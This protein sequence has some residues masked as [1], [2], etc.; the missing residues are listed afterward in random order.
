MKTALDKRFL[1][2][3]KRGYISRY[4]FPISTTLAEQR[5]GHASIDITFMPADEL[6]QLTV[7]VGISPDVLRRPVCSRSFTPGTARATPPFP[8]A[9]RSPAGQSC[10]NYTRSLIGRGWEGSLG[11]GRLEAESRWLGGHNG[12]YQSFMPPACTAPQSA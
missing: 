11:A 7:T 2:L 10:S 3:Q 5:I 4:S 1:D 9:S 6:V 8:S 12:K